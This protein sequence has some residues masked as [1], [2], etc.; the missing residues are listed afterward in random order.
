M[1]ILKSNLKECYLQNQ[2]EYR[3][4]NIGKEEEEN[5]AFWYR[6]L[7]TD[8]LESPIFFLQLLLAVAPDRMSAWH[9]FPLLNHL[10]SPYTLTNHKGRC[11]SHVLSMH[12]P[13]DS[14][15]T[16]V[17]DF[18]KFILCLLAKRDRFKELFTNHTQDPHP[19]DMSFST[20]SHDTPQSW[21]SRTIW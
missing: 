19:Q 3:W 20:S 18:S 5:P 12:R 21:L 6:V 1:T 11:M 9:R 4:E 14:R 13:G 17:S 2:D 10:S 15:Q 16:A 7:S 8:S